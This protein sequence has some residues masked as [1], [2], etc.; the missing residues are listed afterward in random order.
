MTSRLPRD[1]VL[2]YAQSMGTRIRHERRF[3]NRARRG[4]YIALALALA[5]AFALSACSEQTDC[6]AQLV[7][8]SGTYRGKAS[9][10]AR[11]PG[12]VRR[13]ATRDACLTM[14][15]QTK[16]VNME[17]CPPECVVDAEA[18]KVGVK[19]QCSRDE[20]SAP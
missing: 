17:T 14:C 11:D 15:L 1:L 3:S 13:K 6:V 4:S 18:G 10:P 7:T 8:G 9:G 16:A 5:S 19:V 20:V 2:D 12:P